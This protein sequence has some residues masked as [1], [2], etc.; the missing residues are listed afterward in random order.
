MKKFFVIS[1]LALSMSGCAAIKDQIPSFW[2]DNQ[3]ASIVSVRQHVENI[4][5][6]K[7]QA[8]QVMT[9]SQNI[10]WFQ[11][12]SESK[13]SLQKDVLRVVDPMSKTVADWQSRL[14]QQAEAPSRAYCE[15][16]KK[17]LTA[18]SKLAAQAV[19]GRY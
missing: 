17:L 19:L 15:I 11:L 8:P 3:S 14:D 18:Q 5:C 9:I 2:D 6:A 16:K 1:V 13:G 4:D 10:R 7:P 12:Y